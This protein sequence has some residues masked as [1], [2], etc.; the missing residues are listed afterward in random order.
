MQAL[1]M[2]FHFVNLVEQRTQ[3]TEEKRQPKNRTIKRKR[4]GEPHF[5]KLGGEEIGQW[6]KISTT[7]SAARDQVVK[8]RSSYI[9]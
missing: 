2:S 1:S 5:N 7:D 3:Q 9:W 6:H 4:G 8:R